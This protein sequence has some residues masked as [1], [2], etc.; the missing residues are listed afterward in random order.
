[1]FGPEKRLLVEIHEF[2]AGPFAN[3]DIRVKN[4]YIR[5]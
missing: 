2:G 3:R 5:G 4:L 1:M